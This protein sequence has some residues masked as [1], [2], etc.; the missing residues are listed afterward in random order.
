MNMLRSKTE[1]LFL[2]L[3]VALGNWFY[4]DAVVPDVDESKIES[5]KVE[6]RFS[7]SYDSFTVNMKPKPTFIC[8]DQWCRKEFH[9]SFLERD[10]RHRSCSCKCNLAG[11]TSF[12][13][14]IRRCIN[15]SEAARFAGNLMRRSF[16]R[17][18]GARTS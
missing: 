2:F 10:A 11:Y 15:A 5:W 13:P 7:P 12:L 18:T 4:G 6:R 3:V 8:Y 17:K 14:S 9:A 16:F 1:L